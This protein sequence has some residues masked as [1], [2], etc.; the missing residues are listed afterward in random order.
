MI[1]LRLG[2]LPFGTPEPLARVLD[3]KVRFGAAPHHRGMS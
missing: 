2:G 3:Y 1:H